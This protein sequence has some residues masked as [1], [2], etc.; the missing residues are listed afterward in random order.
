M[1]NA[2]RHPGPEPG[3]GVLRADDGSLFGALDVHLDEVHFRQPQ[4]R[5][6]LVDGG[7]WYFD[8]LPASEF[9]EKTILRGIGRIELH[10]E[11][12]V[13]VP[14]AFRVDD[15]TAGRDFRGKIS[16]QALQIL[17]SRFNRDHFG[18]ARPQCLPG[19]HAD[20][21]AGIQDDI[22]GANSSSV[23]V[24]FLFT[25]IVGGTAVSR[26]RPEL[27]GRRLP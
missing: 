5:D 8:G 11:D 19:E 1:I 15:H 16:P 7:Q 9:P 24:S 17:R 10:F 22:A 12:V 2:E 6:H 26:G 23:D 20:V 4:F 21:R 27:A 13:L 18:R 3:D 25:Q 14:N